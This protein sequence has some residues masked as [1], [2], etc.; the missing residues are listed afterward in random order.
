MRSF[1]QN[2]NE[3]YW[4]YR[5]IRETINMTLTFSFFELKL[6]QYNWN[7]IVISLI[8]VHRH[9]HK[10]ILFIGEI[11]ETR[12]NELLS[13]IECFFSFFIDSFCLIDHLL[14]S[15]ICLFLA[16]SLLSFRTYKNTCTS[17]ILW[18]YFSFPYIIIKI[19]V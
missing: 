13:I 3:H 7:D 4:I 11:T 15:S 1:V 14:N 18:A 19:S 9:D 6:K 2:E 10:R 5:L 12:V 8:L 16:Q 17:N